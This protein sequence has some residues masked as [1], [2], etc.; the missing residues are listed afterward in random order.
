MMG[1][2]PRIFILIKLA[3]SRVDEIGSAI[4]LSR[5][6]S[7]VVNVQSRPTALKYPF[8]FPRD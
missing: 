5:G 1:T 2:F 7:F 4:A 3:T 6:P 8:L